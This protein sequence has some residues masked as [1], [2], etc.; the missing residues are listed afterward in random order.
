VKKWGYLS[1]LILVL[2]LLLSGCSSSSK[3]STNASKSSSNSSNSSQSKQKVTVVLKTL[4]SQYWKFVE[5]GAKQAFKDQGV[6]GQVIGPSS[7]SAVVDQINMM[8]DS[9]SKGTD[10]LVVSPSQPDTA[11]PVLKQFANKK[12]PVLL[13]DTDVNWDGK[14][15]FIGTQNYAAGQKAGE[16]LAGMVKKGGK[17][18]LIA[19]ALGNPATD[20]RIKGA[21]DYLE[22]HG[23]TI[24][25]EQPADSDR[26]KAMTVMSNI[27]ESNPDI[28][29][30]YSA[31]DDMALGALRALQAKNKK[32]P[33]IGTDGT[34]DAVNSII[35]GG[36]SATIAQMPYDM[37]YQG[38]V[39][40]VKAI[41]G[42]KVDKRIDSGV[43]VIT[44][45]NAKDKLKKLVD[46][47]K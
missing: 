17:I 29:G 25:A 42:E 35:D 22:K 47:L 18:A 10:A 23:Y 7:E 16:T 15:T 37:G 14:V 9:L 20:D 6:D 8:Q 41:K 13:I 5:A 11:I 30:V 33:V 38:V 21:K 19:G 12:I 34:I 45:D 4:S 36:L 40:A 1:V 32:V 44:K 26:A 27:L 39:N 2:S 31:N 3:T 28:N 43:D 24:V 46:M